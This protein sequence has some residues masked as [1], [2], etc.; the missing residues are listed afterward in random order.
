LLLDPGL[1]KHP[2]CELRVSDSA[3]IFRGVLR[4]ADVGKWLQPIIDRVH[5]DALLR[6]TNEITVDI[7]DVE[8]ANAS[9]WKCFVYWLRLLSDDKNAS[10]RLR[11][12]CDKRRHWQNVGVPF[13][14]VFGSERLSLIMKGDSSFD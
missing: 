1:L 10:Y 7:C 4:D 12:V 8:Y 13:L 11:L 9:A 6:G 2:T 5:A 14:R 3:L